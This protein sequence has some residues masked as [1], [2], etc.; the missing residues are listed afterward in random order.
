MV[1]KVRMHFVDIHKP[2][3]VNRKPDKTAVL[4]KSGKFREQNFIVSHVELRLYEER[5]DD[6]L[7]PYSL[8]TSF[9]NT[10]RGSIEMIYDE[11][12][13]GYDVL[14]RTA[15][16]IASNLGLSAL[17][18]RSIIALEDNMKQNA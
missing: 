8:I 3:R 2:E 15:R 11:G 18:L 13:R 6:R 1:K 17:I 12:F 4:L 5:I 9:V 14:A 16:F 10:N 7:G